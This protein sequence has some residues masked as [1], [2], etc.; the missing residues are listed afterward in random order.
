MIGGIL[1]FFCF[2]LWLLLTWTFALIF[3]IVRGRAIIFDMIYPSSDTKVELVNLWT[4]F[5][6]IDLNLYAEISFS[7]FGTAGH[8]VPQ[9]HRI[10]KCRLRNN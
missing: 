3:L 4:S 7:D 2:S 8:S 6:G 9:T 10:L 1:F 5:C